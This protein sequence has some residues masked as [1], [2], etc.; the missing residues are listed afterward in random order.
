MV[1]PYNYA[2][3]LIPVEGFTGLKDPKLVRLSGREALSQ[4]FQYEL[5]IMAESQQGSGGVVDAKALLGNSMTVALSLKA[6]DDPRYFNGIV[7]QFDH[8][9]YG[10]R[11]H[12]YRA[13]LRPAFWLLTQRADCRIF[14]KKSVTDIFTE[15]CKQGGLSVAHR[16]ALRSS[17]AQWEYRVQ[18]RESDFNF[19]SRLLEHEGIYY[20]FEH[21][22][23]KHEMVL[24][25]DVGKAQSVTNY[26]EVPYYPPTSAANTRARDHLSSWSIQETLQPTAIG[27]ADYNFETPSDPLIAVT[28]IAS[29]RDTSKYEL[30]EYPAAPH[31]LTRGSVELLTKVRAEELGAARAVAKSDGDAAGLC[32]GHV[33]KLIGHPRADLNKRYLI[34]SSCIEAS[35]ASGQTGGAAPSNA[36][37]AVRIETIDATVPYRPERKT[38]KPL[39]QGTQTALVVG[40]KDQD[41]EVWTDKFGRVKVQFY[42]DRVGARDAANACWVR[43]A[44]SWTGSKWGAQFVPRIEQEVVVSFYDGDPDRP[45]VIGC[46]YNALMPPPYELPANSTRSGIKTSS[47]PEGKADQFNE[48]RFEDKINEEHIY[49]HAQKDLQVVVEN[50]QTITVGTKD[51]G[52]RSATI[53]HDDKL[54]VSNDLVVTVKKNETHTVRNN[55]TSK[56]EGDDV[57]DVTKKY[58]LT[59]GVELSLI[60]G[61]SK[62][63]MKKDGTIEISG[64]NVKV[65]GANEVAVEGTQTAL[66]GTQVDVKGTKT[67]VEG[68]ATLDLSA[69]GVATLKGSVTKIG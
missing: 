55:R 56:V 18:Y 19:L 17:Y 36:G 14:M 13:V 8:V 48:L 31:T 25:D 59:A 16:L 63:L 26:E 33:F 35:S 21:S 45:V 42:W 64:V 62:I 52:D 9:G 57:A 34:V 10:E 51:K 24:T 68:S 41:K 11:Y 5:S 43:V 53:A 39:I 40:P 22:R 69:S 3:A 50:D 44:Q 30:F 28:P 61:S 46:V 27:G 54:T 67:A 32:A 2:R 38:P 65:K 37:V 60:C 4:P 15:V 49:L 7:T 23:G 66:S 29:R 1:N 47:S 6:K 58:T 20:Y 12:E